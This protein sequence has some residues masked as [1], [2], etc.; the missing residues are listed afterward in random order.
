MTVLPQCF[1]C[2]HYRLPPEV[3]DGEPRPPLACD[4]FPGGIPEPILLNE[5]DHRTP[6]PGDRGIL[7]EPGEPHEPE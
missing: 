6:Y 2:K 3:A 5:H 7:L 1:D 4:A